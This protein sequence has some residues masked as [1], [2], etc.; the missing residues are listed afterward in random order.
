M[1]RLAL[2]LGKTISEMNMSWREFSYWQ[3]Y[4][5]IEPPEEGDNRRTAALMA[6]ITNMSGRVLPDRKTVS[7][8]DFFGNSASNQQ[9]MD[10]QIAFMKSMG[11]SDGR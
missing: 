10:E 4:F 6:Q 2:L 7:P 3:A 9:S 1:F 11:K 8:D 5:K